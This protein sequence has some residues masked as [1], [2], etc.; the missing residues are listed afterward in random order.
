[1]V[2]RKG[3]MFFIL[4]SII[5]L[6]S[7]LPLASAKMFAEKEMKGHIKLLAVSEGNN[8]VGSLADLY[9]EIK[10]GYGNVYMDTFPLTKMD[11]QLS[12]RFA[13]EVACKFLRE[14]KVDCSKYDFFYTIKAGSSIIGGPSA[15]AGLS[16]LTVALLDPE[17]DSNGFNGR[18]KI[19]DTI[20]ITGTINTGGIIGSVG[21]VKAKITA[22]AQNH[23]TK[24]LIPIGSY[25]EINETKLNKT[26]DDI[27]DTIHNGA[28]NISSEDKTK[29][30]TKNK[31][32][33]T[34]ISDII[35][36]R[37]NISDVIDFVSYGKDNNII[38]VEVLTLR[39]AMKEFTGKE[40][41]RADGEIV[42]DESYTA[43]MA[44]IAK[45]LCERG[46]E[47]D[48]KLNSV[49]KTIIEDENNSLYNSTKDL[50]EKAKSALENKQHYSAASYCFGSNI[51]LD[52][53]I[54]LNA[55]MTMEEKI[56]KID[57]LMTAINNSN[58]I[59]DDMNFTSF[60][61]LQ[62]YLIVKDRLVEAFDTLEQA[63]ELTEHN[64]TNVEYQLAYTTE[65]LF[66]AYSWSYFFNK[67]SQS[68]KIVI[69]D[70]VLEDSCKKIIN[71][72]QE[73][74]EY[75]KIMYPYPLPLLE[76]TAKGIDRA[77]QNFNNRQFKM[78]VMHASKA[79]A[80]IDA[81]LSSIN[82]GDEQLQKL[83]NAKLE[84]VKQVILE[85]QRNG[86]FPIE[87][88]SYYEYAKAL[89]ENDKISG[90]I[91]SQYALE[92]S[93]LNL[94]FEIVKET[95]FSEKVIIFIK[96]ELGVRVILAFLIGFFSAVMLFVS[97]YLVKE[98][99]VN[100]NPNK[101]PKKFARERGVKRL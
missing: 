100:I 93:N 38:V 90:L 35:I 55:N 81:V 1:M 73:R 98:K 87:G 67:T 66:S 45:E 99:K 47:L 36:T 42:L 30:K 61:D 39:D 72:A 46:K 96:D 79:K 34:N 74:F 43:T 7:A 78:C 48:N 9:L 62:T 95:G 14:E 6:V 8:D 51:N 29:N 53:F 3:N 60:N 69:D 57:E 21:G 19:D 80:E 84:L 50:M 85:Q 68:E 59:L 28:L 49:V 32:S 13:K 97:Y 20:A 91:Y 92:F 10:E 2:I 76:S 25:M 26:L 44:S 5:I 86:L 65:R 70:K 56:K 40:Y 22:A 94:Y 18:Y 11:T 23:I 15:G 17:I 77:F 54:L 31:T 58:R 83:L 33:K 4:I 27:N 12:T 75:F 89:G 37:D 64:N 16:M 71:E 24:V 88:Y 41:K 52:Y 63:S 101:L 82:L